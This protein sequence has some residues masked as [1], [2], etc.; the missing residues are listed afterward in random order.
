M[1]MPLI[2]GGGDYNI[3]KGSVGRC[4]NNGFVWMVIN[5]IR[6]TAMDELDTYSG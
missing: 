2:D 4:L 3:I 1:V 5:R 6:K